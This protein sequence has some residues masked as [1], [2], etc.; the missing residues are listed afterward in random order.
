[1]EGE[2]QYDQ[3]KV[4][5]SLPALRGPGGR[6]IINGNWA[7]D[8]PGAYTASG[9]VFLYSRP[10]REEGRVESLSADGPTT[11]PVDVYVSPGTPKEAF[12]SAGSGA[13]SSGR[14]GCWDSLSSLRMS[15]TFSSQMIFQE[16]NPGV[17]YQYVISSPP[18]VLESPTAEPPVPPLQPGKTGGRGEPEG[19]RGGRGD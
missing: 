16:D 3:L 12:L 15:I 18:P 17:S 19:L 4:F 7:V 14:W 13:G 11:Q 6:S 10:P 8:P 5:G 9:T 2:R 1:M